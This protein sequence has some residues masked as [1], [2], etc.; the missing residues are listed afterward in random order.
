F[1]NYLMQS[2]IALVLFYVIGFGFY[3]Q[4]ERYQLYLVVFAV[5]TFQITFSHIWLH[6][7]RFG[8]FEWLWRSLTY[9]K[10]QPMRKST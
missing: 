6:Y 9:W 10:L 5:W 3:G 7:Y 2:L 4:M 8:P 1:T